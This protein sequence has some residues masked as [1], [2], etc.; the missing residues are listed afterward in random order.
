MLPLNQ[1]APDFK[2]YNTQKKEVSLHEQKGRN[3][4]LLFFPFAFTSTCT[5]ELC[6][7]RDNISTYNSLNAT[8][9]G[10]SVDSFYTL[11]KYKEEQQLN[12]ELLSDFNKEVSSA[13]DCIYDTFGLGLKGVSKRGVFVIDK[14]GVLRHSEVLENASNLP[15]FEAINA[16]LKKLN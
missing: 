1:K 15:D 2:L 6:T 8:I 12:F 13:Y 14:E 3:V 11:A 5:K 9:Y 10:I 4:V 16:S 7:M